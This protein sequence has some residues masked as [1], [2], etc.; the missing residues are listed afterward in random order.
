MNI[1]LL[2]R[3]YDNPHYKMSDEQMQEYIQKT[4]KPMI[5][6]GTPKVEKNLFAK[7]ETN[8]VKSNYE[9]KKTSKPFSNRSKR[10]Q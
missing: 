2:Q 1:K 9:T 8:I 6:F 7:H 10:N 5:S 3:L 4:R